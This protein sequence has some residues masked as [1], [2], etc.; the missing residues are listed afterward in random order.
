MGQGGQADTTI[1]SK[2]PEQNM[3]RSNIELS[4]NIKF[5]TE[6]IQTFIAPLY[7]CLICTLNSS[8]ATQSEVREI[9]SLLM[10]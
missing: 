10:I 4:G 8:E 5:S 6:V 9:L 2:I 7:R 3:F 1:P